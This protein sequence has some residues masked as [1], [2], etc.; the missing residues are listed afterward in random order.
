MIRRQVSIF[1]FCDAELSFSGIAVR[2]VNDILLTKY[3]FRAESRYDHGMNIYMAFR[4]KISESLASPP[5]HCWHRN[6]NPKHASSCSEVYNPSI[7]SA[8][9]GQTIG[10]LVSWEIRL[11]RENSAAIISRTTPPRLFR[12]T[13]RVSL[14]GNSDAVLILID[15]PRDPE[16]S[17]HSLW[18]PRLSTSNS[19]F[20]R[21][22]NSGEVR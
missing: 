4:R 22:M 21:L 19:S 3:Y 16:T 10:D 18:F 12:L 14:I 8:L 1:L 11:P 9:W 20:K 17:D 7:L 5:K 15:P 13:S 6:P 2:Y